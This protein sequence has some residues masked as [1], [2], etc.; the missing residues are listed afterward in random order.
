VDKKEKRHSICCTHDLVLPNL[1]IA[2]VFVLQPLY[3]DTFSS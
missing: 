1:R 3:F 2:F